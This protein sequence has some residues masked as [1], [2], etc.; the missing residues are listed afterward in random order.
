MKAGFKI[1]LA[2]GLSALAVAGGTATAGADSADGTAGKR[3]DCSPDT[4]S[5]ATST[6]ATY[7]YTVK[8][9]NVSC[10]KAWKVIKAFHACRKAHGGARGHCNSR[11]K[12]YKCDEGKRDNVV[13]G[14][15]YRANVVC[16]KGA[17]KV[18]H[19]YEMAY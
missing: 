15:R 9:K 16:K 1:T 7:V 19:E 14:V 6:Y 17:K 8:T 10:G 4:A 5:E 13:A 3:A 12:H 2:L 11:V 18:K